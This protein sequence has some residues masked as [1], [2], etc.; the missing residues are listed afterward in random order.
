[1]PINTVYHRQYG[2]VPLCKDRTSASVCLVG[3]RVSHVVLLCV[4]MIVYSTYSTYYSN[5]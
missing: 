2:N 4:F 5:L 3:F 1:M